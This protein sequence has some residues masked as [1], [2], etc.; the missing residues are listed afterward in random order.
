MQLVPWPYRL[1]LDGSGE[2][3]HKTKLGITGDCAA[4]SA[5]LGDRETTSAV[6]SIMGIGDGILRPDSWK[7]LL[8]ETKMTILC[9]N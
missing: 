3:I 1:F 8:I 9:E 4:T 6:Y 5:I 7:M 2:S